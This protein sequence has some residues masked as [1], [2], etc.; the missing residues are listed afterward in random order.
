MSVVFGSM[1]N[2]TDVQLNVL[3]LDVVD[4]VMQRGTILEIQPMNFHETGNGEMNE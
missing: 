4:L 1:A 2:A 3:D